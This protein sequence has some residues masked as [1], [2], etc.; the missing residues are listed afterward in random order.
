MRYRVKVLPCPLTFY[1]CFCTWLLPASAQS[2]ALGKP[3]VEVRV[4]QEGQTIIDPL[5]VDLI[6]TEVGEPLSMPD[7][8]ESMDHLFALGRYDDVQ[9]LQEAVGEGVRVIYRLMPSHPVQQ[10]LYRGNLGLP[11]AQLSQA[12]MDRY[13]ALPKVGRLEEAADSL[14]NF[15]RDHGY[16]AASVTPIVEE[17]HEPDRSTVIFSIDA[18]PRARVAR[19]AVEGLSDADTAALLKRLPIQPGRP[20]DSVEL[21]EALDEY[22]NDMRERGFYEIGVIP[23]TET[24]SG[25]EVQVTIDIRVGPR[26]TIAF[27]GDPLPE[28]VQEEL[29]PVREE[30]SVDEDLLENASFAIRNYL[31]ARGYR[32]ADAT[33]A[34]EEREGELVIRFNVRRGPRHV[35][36]SII[37]EG[38]RALTAGAQRALVPLKSGEPFVEAALEAAAGAIREAYR[39]RGFTRAAVE[40]TVGLLPPS[41]AGDRRVAVT[42]TITE[43]PRTMVDAVAFEGNTVLSADY[44]GPLLVTAPGRSYSALQVA[45]DAERIRTD[46]LDRGY[47]NVVV[48]PRVILASDTTRADVRFAISEGPQVMVDHVI[49]LGNER[50]KRATIE[51]ELAFRSGEPLGYSSLI[52]SQRRLSALGLFRRIRITERPHGSEPRRDVIVDVEEAPPTT[53][54][55]GGGLEGGLRLRPTAEGGQAEERFELAPRAFFQIGRRNLFGKNRSIDL[56]TRVS[57]RARDIVLSPEGIRLQRPMEGEYGFNE[58]RVLAAYREPRIFDSRADVRVTGVLDQAIRSSFNFKTREIFTE[59]IVRP[60]PRYAITGTYSYRHTELF[61]ERFEDDEK[62]L[63]DRLFPQVRLSTVSAT[64]LRDTRND[65]LDPDRGAFLA[66]ENKVA[67]R[68]FGSEVGFVRTYLEAFTYRRLPGRRR[69]IT[70]LGARLG[71]AQGF[72]RTLPRLDAGGNPVTGPD[73]RPL[74]DVVQDLPASERFFAGGDTTVRGFSLDRLGDEQTITESGFPRGG[75]GRIVLNAELRIALF[76]GFDGVT[77][78]D[79]GNVF[80]RVTNMKLTKLRAAVGFGVRYRSPVGPIRVDLGFNLDRRELVPGRLEQRPVLH[81]SL[82]QAF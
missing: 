58:Y 40:Q 12:V 44:L 15:Y 61:D 28:D 36:D 54:G 39:A 34:R 70:A 66:A 33:H 47:Q 65:V 75:N 31:L 24:T 37:L 21:R 56:F 8:R 20:Y 45:S 23:L 74:L 22:E 67:A 79:A 17:T 7:V 18:G 46:Y 64:L 10:V 76:G 35:V 1:L 41:E 59:A 63:I 26:V 50:T 16:L 55:Y 71:A 77:F 14:R 4:E 29:V 82:G 48:E 6:E 52:E 80:P 27:A 19:I 73:G 3:I 78:L 53:L 9:V 72:R 38:S 42:L 49:I 68:A 81:I 25:G 62:P 30:G 13:G 57:L 5:V 11:Q 2:P 32:D 69:V 60:S 51:R 43:G